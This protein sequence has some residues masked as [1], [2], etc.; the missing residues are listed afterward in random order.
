MLNTKI[1]YKKKLKCVE[2]VSINQHDSNE[3]H[4]NNKFENKKRPCV[5]K[6][7]DIYIKNHVIDNHEYDNI[8]SKVIVFSKK[9]PDCQLT[10]KQIAKYLKYI[11][12]NNKMYN[13]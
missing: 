1:H 4:K 9:N 6:Y 11:N 10:N 13:T 7:Y 12:N 2:N 8:Q 3:N 5:Y